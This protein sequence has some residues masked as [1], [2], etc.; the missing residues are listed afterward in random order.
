MCSPQYAINSNKQFFIRQ[1]FVEQIPKNIHL[2][3]LSNYKTNHHNG[4]KFRNE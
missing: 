2:E 1:D 4:N 3:S